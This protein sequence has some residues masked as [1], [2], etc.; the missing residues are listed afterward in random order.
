VVDTK[1]GELVQVDV[2]SGEKK[3][4]A[5]LKPALDN[6]AIDTKRGHLY[7][8]NMADNSIE[9]VDP[10]TGKSRMIVKG[11][12]SSPAGIGLV[13]DTIYVAD[14]F[15]FRTVDTKTG[16]VTEV[17]RMQNS[18]LEY[19]NSATANDKTVLLS[20]WFTGTV[21]VID[22]SSLKTREMLHGFKAPH[23]AVELPDGSLLVAEL[24]SGSLLQVKGEHGKERAAVVSGLQG[25]AGIALSKDGAIAYVTEAAGRVWEVKT[26]DWSKRQVAEGL[27]LPE[28]IALTPKGRLV[29]VQVGTQQ[30]VEIDPANGAK[31]VVADKVPVGRPGLPGLPPTS[32]FSGIAVNDAG[33]IF[34]PSDLNQGLYRIR[35]D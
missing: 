4:V 21:Q 23:D 2:K 1:S 8:S 32:V 35:L 15:A 13:G 11:S 19:P 3:T 5:Q 34:F 30:I 24:G 16:K 9:E 7:V 28:G 33:D 6:L 10:A 18:D 31:K 12:L 14:T 20:S 26:K 22:R 17:A 29:V 25:P 27:K